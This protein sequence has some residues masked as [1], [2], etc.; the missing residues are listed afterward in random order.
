[1]IEKLKGKIVKGIGGFYYVNVPQKGL[2]ECR[3]RGL[4]RNQNCKPLV[5][6]SVILETVQEKEFTGYIIEILPKK[7]AATS[8]SSKYWSG[9]NYFCCCTASAKF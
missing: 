2:Y 9:N 6:D 3:A 8:F 5:G 4:F 1:M 7:W